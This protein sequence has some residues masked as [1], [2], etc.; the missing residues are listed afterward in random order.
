[1]DI[2]AGTSAFVTHDIV[3]ENQYAFRHG[4]RVVVESITPNPQRPEYKYVVVSSTLQKRFQLSDSDVTVQTTKDVESPSRV[5]GAVLPTGGALVGT[6]PNITDE[7]LNI[8]GGPPGHEGK[9]NPTKQSLKDSLTKPRPNLKFKIEAGFMI[10]MFLLAI[11]IGINWL[12]QKGKK[13]E[14]TG[15]QVETL[16]SNPTNSSTEV[17]T[18]PQPQSQATS[19]PAPAAQTSPSPPDPGPKP[20]DITLDEYNQ[21]QVGMTYEQVV[22]IV[23]DPGLNTANVPNFDYTPPENGAAYVFFG[24]NPNSAATA[25]FQDGVLISKFQKGL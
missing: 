18:T 14:K 4:E 2:K 7:K 8:G 10:V 19:T 21:I 1:M 25:V 17:N 11:I 3:I 6:K 15:T 24:H 16:E 20:S 23:G 9:L 12:V 22:A 5:E 13:P